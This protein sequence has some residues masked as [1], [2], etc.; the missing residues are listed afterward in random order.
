[1]EFTIYNFYCVGS[2]KFTNYD[3][4]LANGYKTGL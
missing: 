3:H 2:Q 1:M 4:S